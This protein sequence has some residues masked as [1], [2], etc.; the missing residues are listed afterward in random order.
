M[1]AA[2]RLLVIALLLAD[3]TSK[4]IALKRLAG[5]GSVP[6]IPGFFHLTLVWNTGSLWG[7]GRTWPW[8]W[9]GFNLVASVLLY[10]WLWRMSRLGDF[11]RWPTALLLAGALGNLVDRLGRGAVVD[12]LD[13]SIAGWH[14]PAF[15]LADSCLT[16]GILWLASLAFR[17]AG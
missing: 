8:F 5:A 15:N 17:P 2:P 11:R 3:Q 10:L 4:M 7:I 1:S 6:V 9:T 16:V 14:W 13:F 12:F